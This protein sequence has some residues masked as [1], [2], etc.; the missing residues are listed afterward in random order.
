MP[1]ILEI[2]D[3]IEENLAGAE[4]VVMSGV[5]YMVNME[6]PEQFNEI[7][8]DFLAKTLSH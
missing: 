2:G 4:V 8:L 5:A 3:A 1:G 7:V 6:G